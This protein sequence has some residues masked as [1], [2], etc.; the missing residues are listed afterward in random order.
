MERRIK[1]WFKTI[2]DPEIRAKAITNINPILI[3]S[4]SDSLHNSLY[5]A[6]RWADSPEEHKYWSEFVTTLNK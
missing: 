4:K 1:K 6:F 2:K 5:D 3:N